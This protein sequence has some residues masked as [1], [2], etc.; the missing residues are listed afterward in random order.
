MPANRT[1]FKKGNCANP[2]GRPKGLPNKITSDVK[3]MILEALNN[4]GGAAYL[5]RQA[6]ENPVAFMSLVGKVLPMQV[7]GEG[8]APLKLI[9]VTGVPE[10]ESGA[11]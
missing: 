5:E 3:A 2:N 6:D 9:V 7:T 8:G 1:S 11:A 4:K 10:S